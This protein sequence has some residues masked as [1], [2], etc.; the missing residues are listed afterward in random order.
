MIEL[1][2]ETRIW[3]AA[4]MTDMRRGFD[5]LS[6]QVQTMKALVIA[7]HSESMEQ[8]KEL[9]SNAHKIER[10]KLVLFLTKISS[11]REIE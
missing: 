7:K 5:G 10:L 4:G 2:T 9:I 6:A 1:R 11:D 8:H 3:L